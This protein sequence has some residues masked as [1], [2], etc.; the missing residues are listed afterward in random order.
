MIY[1]TGRSRDRIRGGGSSVLA[2]RTVVRAGNQGP[3]LLL[4]CREM[5]AEKGRL[6]WACEEL[7]TGANFFLYLLFSC[8]EDSKWRER[9]VTLTFTLQRG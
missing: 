7:G 6:L 4:A 9:M 5:V 1:G 8:D 2:A 3:V